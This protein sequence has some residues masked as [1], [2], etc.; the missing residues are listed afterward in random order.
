[1]SKKDVIVRNDIDGGAGA[2]AGIRLGTQ[3]NSDGVDDIFIL[4]NTVSGN[5]NGIEAFAQNNGYIDVE[6][7]TFRHNRTGANFRSGMID[8]T[9][10]VTG[11]GNIFRGGRDAL[12]FDNIYGSTTY[13]V[14]LKNDS[15]GAQVFVN[16]AR[17]YVNLKNG[18][19]FDPGTP[20]VIDGTLATY[21]HVPGGLMTQSQLLAV[22]AKINDYRDDRTLGL[23]FAGYAPFD[24]N[25]ILEKVLGARYQAGRAGIIITGLPHV[26]PI[27]GG[28]RP[29][30]SLQD[31]A[32][33]A[34]AAG[35]DDS[36]GPMSV[37]D[38]LN[39]EPAAGGAGKGAKAHVINGACWGAVGGAGGGS[40]VNIA[41]DGDATSILADL[42]SCNP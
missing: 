36:K 30:F 35:G 20:T 16:Q 39:I 22:N 13:P 14:S 8:L 26:G 33:L 19:L 1:L 4:R 40:I 5:R 10:P 7:N 24:D 11:R 17:Y 2:K 42:A 38:I 34:P 6:A 29:F 3:G 15:L 9:A 21:D 25:R 32:D 28:Y 41:L 23:V 37:Q 18:A 27:K 12:V 31:L